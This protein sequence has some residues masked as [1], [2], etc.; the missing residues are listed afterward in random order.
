MP[1]R[2]RSRIQTCADDKFSPGAWHAVGCWDNTARRQFKGDRQ[3]ISEHVD[4][5]E[6]CHV[7][8]TT[9]Q[10]HELALIILHNV[11]PSKVLQV[12]HVI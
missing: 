1:T 4:L 8:A 7:I 10:R 6:L 12:Q 11:G 9:Q 5:L 3:P 2:L